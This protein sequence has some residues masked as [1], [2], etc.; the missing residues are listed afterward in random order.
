M[1]KFKSFCYGFLMVNLLWWLLALSMSRPIVPAPLAVY[2]NLGRVFREH[3]MVLHIGHSMWRLFSSL[4]ISLLLGLILGLAMARSKFWDKVLDP[5]I[6]F[7][8]P[9]PKISLLP[10][11]MVLFGLGDLS[12]V[13]MIVM[14]VVFQVIINVRDG[15]R[16][17]PNE[18]Y[19]IL[20]CLGAPKWRLF[21]KITFPAALASIISSL[22]V[23]LGTGLSILFFIENYGTRLGVG[24]YI[25]NAWSRMN[26]VDMYSGIVVLSGLGFA[27]FLLLD[28]IEAHFLKW[29]ES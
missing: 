19:Q 16:A 25:L 8:Y 14:I 28:L 10:V 22:R 3:G 9:I 23:A 21:T 26:W 27:F 6:Y 4:F 24:Y 17:I 15:V 18:S 12:K 20:H 13:T 2:A 1:A 7:T 5:F 11:V 29:R